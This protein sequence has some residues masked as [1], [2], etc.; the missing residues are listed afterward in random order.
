MI[1]GPSTGLLHVLGVT[2]QAS[3]SSSREPKDF[4]LK[5]AKDEPN[6]LI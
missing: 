4:K 6:F 2:A 3:A 5:D 1:C